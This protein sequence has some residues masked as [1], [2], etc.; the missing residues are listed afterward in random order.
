MSDSNKPIEQFIGNEG[1]VLPVKELKV[2]MPKV[3]A[4]K[5]TDKTGK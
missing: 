4:P 5:P 2:P 3:A 1:W